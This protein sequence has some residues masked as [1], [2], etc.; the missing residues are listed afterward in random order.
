M[1]GKGGGHTRGLDGR[2][3]GR[4]VS[5]PCSLPGLPDVPATLPPLL[6][7]R[8]FLL[9]HYTYHCYASHSST[10]G[11][12]KWKV[13]KPINDFQLPS[14]S[15]EDLPEVGAP[16]GLGGRKSE[17]VCKSRTKGACGEAEGVTG[18][19]RAVSLRMGA[20]GRGAY[21]GWEVPERGRR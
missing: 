2:W 14:K 16:W 13:Y 7:L 9:S 10:I 4:E 19:L 15:S 17:E 21:R 18:R 12:K 20:P 3:D 1:V 11:S 8:L 6:P 5:C